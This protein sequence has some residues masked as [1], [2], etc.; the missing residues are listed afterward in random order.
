MKCAP[1]RLAIFVAHATVLLVHWLWVSLV[2]KP[3]M[4]FTSI[5]FRTLA[6]Y[7]TELESE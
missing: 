2:K 4:L 6:V 5:A 3:R 1:V 7:P